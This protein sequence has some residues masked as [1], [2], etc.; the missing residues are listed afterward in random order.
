MREISMELK[1]R[2]IK[3]FLAGLTLEEIAAQV[4]V[5]KGS[6]VNIIA[7]FRDGDLPIPARRERIYR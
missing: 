6:V 1:S 2:V 5:S 3:L 4:H 7:G